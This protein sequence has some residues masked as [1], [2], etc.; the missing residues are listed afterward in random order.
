MSA[1]HMVQQLAEAWDQVQPRLQVPADLVDPDAAVGAQQA[2]AVQDGEHA[3]VLRPAEV[4]RQQH[5]EVLG[6]QA[7]QAAWLG[8]GFCNLLHLYSPQA[9]IMGG[10]V[11]QAFD[12]LLPGI[13][14]VV[15][16]V[17]ERR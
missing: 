5:E 6:G 12:L 16:R 7:L 4:V 14:S 9:V 15:R 13:A 17:R 11:S 2:G 3:D 10:G 1:E 8:L